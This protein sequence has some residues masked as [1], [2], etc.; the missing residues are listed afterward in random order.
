MTSLRKIWRAYLA[1]DAH[2]QE[3]AREARSRT[4]QDKWTGLRDVNDQA[5]FMMLFACFEG[6]V[7]ALCHRLVAARRH[8]RSWRWR[9]LWDTV[10]VDRLHFMRKTALLVDKGG[11]DYN[12]IRDLYEIRCS[13]AHGK[14]ERVGP[15]DLPFEYQEIARLWKALRP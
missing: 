6:R 15:L 4:A 1:A 10:D 13:I 8:Q 12:K 14:P 2:L 3:R 7:T 11:T 9:R 5:Y